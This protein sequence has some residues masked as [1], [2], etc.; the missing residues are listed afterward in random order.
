MKLYWVDSNHQKAPVCEHFASIHGFRPPE[1]SLYLLCLDRGG[2]IL[3]LS[4][5]N[6]DLMDPCILFIYVTEENRHQHIGS[7]MLREITS[8]ASK[9]GLGSLRFFTA[10]DM[11]LNSFLKKNGFEIFPGPFI[12]KTTLRSLLYSHQYV[13][14]IDGHSPE[15]ACTISETS[16]LGKEILKG[17]FERE[18][19]DWQMGYDED[20]SLAV[21][22]GAKVQALILCD[23]S[24]GRMT[25]SR[26][27]CDPGDN[28]SLIACLQALNN[29]IKSKAENYQDMTLLFDLDQD[30][31]SQ[32]LKAL[33]GNDIHIIEQVETTIALRLL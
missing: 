26:L 6:S 21:I 17:F 14:E 27:F 33:V 15:S 8:S 9:A 22:N 5:L 32:L 20:F 19:I 24:I 30:K 18:G 2:T 3:G 7:E 1:D 28:S 31:C 11:A 13:T 16:E 23:A 10:P 12:Y 29:R 4:V 25:I